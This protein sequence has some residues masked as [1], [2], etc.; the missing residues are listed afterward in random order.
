MNLKE[1]YTDLT[2]YKY[3]LITYILYI[4]FVDVIMTGMLYTTMM[5]INMYQ[6]AFIGII[7]FIIYQTQKY[8]RNKYEVNNMALQL[9]IVYIWYVS[10]YFDI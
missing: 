5:G 2:M 8:I 4:L 3:G 7:A 6:W 9:T 1:I 10:R